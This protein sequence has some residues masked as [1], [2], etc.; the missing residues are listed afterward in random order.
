MNNSRFFRNFECEYFPCHRTDDT[1]DFNCLF[2]YCPLYCDAHCGGN[3][4]FTSTGIK[5]CSN[6]LLPHKA[7]NYEYI[8]QK[9]INFK[10]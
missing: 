9:L 3:Y 1:E 5:D 2:C 10:K 6:C 8:K 4:T 7:N